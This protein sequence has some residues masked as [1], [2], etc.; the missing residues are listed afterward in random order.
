MELA[1]HVLGCTH[2]T[3]SQPELI[4]YP[5][6]TS[7]SRMSSKDKI[8]MHEKERKTLQSVMLEHV[9]DEEDRKKLNGSSS[10]EEMPYE[11]KSEA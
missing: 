9:N 11:A 3:N 4:R 5:T 2:H 10:E 8:S 7:I 1:D 6:R